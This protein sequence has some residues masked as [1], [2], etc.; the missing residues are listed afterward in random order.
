M[1]CRVDENLP[2]KQHRALTVG[3]LIV[4]RHCVQKRIESANEFVCDLNDNDKQ[5]NKSPVH[6]KFCVK[7]KNH[8]W[9]VSH[10][11]QR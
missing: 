1:S 7:R 5:I 6:R 8:V 2:T 3:L 4:N 11:N 10:I 9:G